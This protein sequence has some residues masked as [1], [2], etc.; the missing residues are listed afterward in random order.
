MDGQRTFRGFLIVEKGEQLGHF[1]TFQSHRGVQ[2]L[3][4]KVSLGMTDVWYL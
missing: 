4:R 3:S 2:S 1:H